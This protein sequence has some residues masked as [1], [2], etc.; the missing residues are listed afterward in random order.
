MQLY[1]FFDSCV[2]VV[3]RCVREHCKVVKV[4]MF[5]LGYTCGDRHSC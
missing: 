5:V 4:C 1:T 3:L 2:A